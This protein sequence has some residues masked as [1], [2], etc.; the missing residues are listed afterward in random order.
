[1]T[2][3]QLVAFNI[4]LLV[5]IASPGPA[6]L[7]AT[8]TAASRG[9][10]A[11]IEVGIGLGLMACTWTMMALLGLAVV[12]QLFPMVYTGVKVLGGAY[13]LF[14]AYKMWRN[15]SAPID[16]RFPLAR[17]AFRQ[18]FLVNLLNP[19][20]V[21]FAAAVLV[22]VFPAGLSVAESFVI[23]INHFMVE[24]AFYTTLAFCMSTQVVSKRYM[25]AKVY[26]DRGA[27]L[28]LGALGT[29]LVLT[30]EEAPLT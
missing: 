20:S 15:A 8:H 10:S 9:R 28:V 3:E 12:F 4:A 21:L 23:V 24:V 18:G 29:R 17:H 25:Q 11:G 13:L 14:L 1:M 2:W 16:A 7:M 6:L 22:A 19:K 5:A 26:I 27:A 30:S